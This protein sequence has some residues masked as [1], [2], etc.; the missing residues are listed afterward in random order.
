[1]ANIEITS[2][3]TIQCDNPNCD[4]EVEIPFATYPEWINKPCPKCGENLLT[5]N[6][7][8][9][10]ELVRVSVAYL[11]S[12]SEEDFKDFA[13]AAE[14]IDAKDIPLFKDAKGIE[15]LDDKD[16]WLVYQYQPTKK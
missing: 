13:K 1:M 10:A 15:L 3:D 12:M 8:K 2:K 7:Y 9:N 11:N 4:Y 16:G 14:T 6:D 5:E